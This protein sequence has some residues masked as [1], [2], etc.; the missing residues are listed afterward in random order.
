MN[1]FYY[2]NK[3]LTILLILL[4]AAVEII[5]SCKNSTANKNVKHDNIV[6][7]DANG[8]ANEGHRFTK[9]DNMSFYLDDIKYIAHNGDLVA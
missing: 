5:T 2:K 6:S 3:K 8:K 9:I 7:I 1:H 4:L